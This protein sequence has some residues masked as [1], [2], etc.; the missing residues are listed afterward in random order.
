M[1][2]KSF[3]NFSPQQYSIEKAAYIMKVTSSSP[4]ESNLL[5]LAL[6]FW[7]KRLVLLLSTAV[8]FVG[9]VLAASLQP[10]SFRGEVRIYPQDNSN[11]TGFDTWNYLLAMVNAQSQVLPGEDDRTFQSFND[12]TFQF[13]GSRQTV[14]LKSFNQAT[15]E[16]TP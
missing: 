1:D 2:N 7:E 15:S 16:A 6:F 8:F 9:G 14:S 13:S 5:D 11:L 12:R 3:I 10:P 4:D